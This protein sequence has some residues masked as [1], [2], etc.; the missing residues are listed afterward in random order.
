MAYTEAPFYPHRRD[1]DG[2]FSSICLTC[3]ATVAIKMTEADLMEE[4]KKHV[5]ISSPISRRGNLS[6]IVSK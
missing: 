3:F 5:C 1:K 6:P 4:E 2:S